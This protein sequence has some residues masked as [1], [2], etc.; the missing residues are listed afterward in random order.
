MSGLFGNHIPPPD[1]L[2]LPPHFSLLSMMTAD[3]PSSTAPSAAARPAAPLPTMTTSNSWS[4]VTMH[5]PHSPDSDVRIYFNY[6]AHTPEEQSGPGGGTAESRG[7]PR[8]REDTV[9]SA[10]LRRSPQRNR[11]GGRGGPRGAVPPL[12]HPAAARPGGFR[13]A[14]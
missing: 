2:E 10:R 6:D 3:K 4:N 1:L 9:R 8:G 13:G 7:T 5:L 14:L 12:P 11:A